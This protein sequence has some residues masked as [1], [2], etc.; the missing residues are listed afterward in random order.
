MASYITV[1]FSK[2][3]LWLCDFITI[4][5]LTMYHICKDLD[6]IN[7]QIILVFSITDKISKKKN[8]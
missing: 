1:Y 7:Q 4:K 6:H 3:K 2:M 8:L 5:P